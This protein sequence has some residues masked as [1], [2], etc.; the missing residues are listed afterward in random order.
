MEG[1]ISAKELKM[2]QYQGTNLRLSF[3][4]HEIQFHQNSSLDSQSRITSV[5]F[6]YWLFQYL[7][8]LCFLLPLSL[9]SQQIGLLIVDCQN[10]SFL[11]ACSL[12]IHLLS[13]QLHEPLGHGTW[14]SQGQN[15]KPQ[16]YQWT[17]C[18]HSDFCCCWIFVQ[19]V[20][21]HAIK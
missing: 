12:L 4:Q 2:T 14:G 3:S 8:W 15:I 21:V 10:I 6:Q 9:F 7:H 20:L 5:G 18:H 19:L 1:F 11:H 13:F 16:W 17:Y